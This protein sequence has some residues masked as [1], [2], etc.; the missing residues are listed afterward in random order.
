[1]NQDFDGLLWSR[2]DDA[3]DIHL[4]ESIS[5]EHTQ[6][7]GRLCCLGEPPALIA[8]ITAARRTRKLSEIR[9]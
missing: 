9:L 6:A 3:R 5:G 1:M 2:S 4:E 7:D 8:M